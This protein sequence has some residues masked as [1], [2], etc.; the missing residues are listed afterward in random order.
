MALP[1]LASYTERIV[2]FV[3]PSFGLPSS[4][5]IRLTRSPIAM[6]GRRVTETGRTDDNNPLVHLR[7]ETQ[8][9][10]LVDSQTFGQA[11]RPNEQVASKEPGR[12]ES[13]ER[14]DERLRR[15][16]PGCAAQLGRQGRRRHLVAAALPSLDPPR[17]QGSPFWLLPN[18]PAAA[19][20]CP[21]RTAPR[22]S[23]TAWV[24]AVPPRTRGAHLFQRNPKCRLWRTA[25]ASTWNVI[26]GVLALAATTHVFS[27]W[28][29]EG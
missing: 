21:S 28:K 17:I 8:F 2:I 14:L 6:I 15:P 1:S 5:R 12:K 23:V 7:P 29:C 18:T 11:A 3:D 20:R 26:R 9:N 19:C 16:K 24:Q 27:E 13:G 10:D 22:S 4:R 25:D